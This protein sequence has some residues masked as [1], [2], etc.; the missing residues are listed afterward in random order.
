VFQCRWDSY[1]TLLNFTLK[2][3]AIAEKTAN[4]FGDN[5]FAAPGVCGWVAY[6]RDQPVAR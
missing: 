1:T 6:G 3:Q 5:S 4:Y 2:F